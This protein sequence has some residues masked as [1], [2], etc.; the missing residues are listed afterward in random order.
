VKIDLNAV[1]IDLN[2]VKIDLV[3][4]IASLKTGSLLS[5]LSKGCGHNSYGEPA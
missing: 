3:S 2:A 1:K 4:K 5:K